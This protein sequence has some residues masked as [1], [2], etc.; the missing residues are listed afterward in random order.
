IYALIA[1]GHNNRYKFPHDDVL[2]RYHERKIP[3]LST[4]DSGAISLRFGREV[5]APEGYRQTARR[6][7]HAQP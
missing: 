6:F 2:E 1:V 3:L 5:S 4:A 7:W